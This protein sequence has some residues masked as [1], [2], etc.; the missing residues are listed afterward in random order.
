MN[1][2][3]HTAKSFA[4]LCLLNL[5]FFVQL[6]VASP[7]TESLQHHHSDAKLVYVAAQAAQHHAELG[8][9]NPVRARSGLNGHASATSHDSFI[10]SMAVIQAEAASGN[11]LSPPGLPPVSALIG[12]DTP[13]ALGRGPPRLFPS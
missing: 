4:A 5:F 11:A 1:L 2:R 7:E 10:F 8:A 9:S 12:R 13:P 6:M 3:S